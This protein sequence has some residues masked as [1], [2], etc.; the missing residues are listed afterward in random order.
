MDK[1]YK[2][3]LKPGESSL[4]DA[5]YLITDKMAELSKAIESVQQD[6]ALLIKI[7]DNTSNRVE[8]L[9]KEKEKSEKDLAD[10]SHRLLVLEREEEKKRRKRQEFKDLALALLLTAVGILAIYGAAVLTGVLSN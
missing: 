1:E 6:S 7:I 2:E 9:T 5:V 10:L 4:Q 3:V 8:V